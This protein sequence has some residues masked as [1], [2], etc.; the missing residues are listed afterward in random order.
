[1]VECVVSSLFFP[2]VRIPADLQ[3]KEVQSSVGILAGTSSIRD[4]TMDFRKVNESRQFP[5]KKL[6]QIGK[7]VQWI[8]VVNTRWSAIYL[9]HINQTKTSITKEDG[10][11]SLVVHVHEL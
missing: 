7:V 9:K 11:K 2:F 8:F 1:M 3:R 10:L 4:T 5:M 6:S